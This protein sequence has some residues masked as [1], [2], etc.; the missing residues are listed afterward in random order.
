MQVRNFSGAIR[1]DQIGDGI[2][3]GVRAVASFDLPIDH[4]QR[5]SRLWSCRT[6]S[7]CPVGDA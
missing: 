4:L 3:A 2:P 1:Q 6:T 5:W 7:G